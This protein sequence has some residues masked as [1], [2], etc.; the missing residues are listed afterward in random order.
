MS[1]AF[2]RESDDEAELPMIR[3]KPPLPPG[4]KNYLTPSGE[5]RL[6]DELARLVQQER[7]KL[8]A[9]PDEA[10]AKRKLAVLDQQ[11][12]QLDESLSTAVVVPTPPLPWDQVRFGATVTVKDSRGGEDSYRIVGVEEMDVDRGWV[13]FLS[14]IA[15]ALLNARSGERVRF[16]FPSGEAT[17]EII[18]ITYEG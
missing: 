8:A 1:K 9:A 10:D 17:L 3:P 2:T 6:R 11:I 5:A 16:E 18:S 14:P 13:S 15:K 12:R 4:V 7:P